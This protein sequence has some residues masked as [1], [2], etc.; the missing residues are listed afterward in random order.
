MRGLLAS[1]HSLGDA[2]YAYAWALGCPSRICVRGL[3]APDAKLQKTSKDAHASLRKSLKE[4]RKNKESKEDGHK[5]KEA[6]SAL[7]ARPHAPDSVIMPPFLNEK[8]FR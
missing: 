5:A 4:A 1:E 3:V 7:I 2:C 8:V 6:H